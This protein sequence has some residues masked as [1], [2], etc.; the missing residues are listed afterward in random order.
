MV[1]T[2][3]FHCCAGGKYKKRKERKTERKRN[4]KDVYEIIISLKFGNPL[5]R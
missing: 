4:K 3:L 1:A 2:A 5:I